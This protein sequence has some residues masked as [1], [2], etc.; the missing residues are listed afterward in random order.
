MGGW[1]SGERMEWKSLGGVQ[2]SGR[3]S[4]DNPLEAEAYL[5]MNA[6]L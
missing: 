1:G 6:Q 3:E 4:G 5:L 2:G